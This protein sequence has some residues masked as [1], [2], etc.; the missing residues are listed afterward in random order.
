[1]ITKVA[2]LKMSLN[3]EDFVLN[4]SLLLSKKVKID[5]KHIHTNKHKIFLTCFFIRFK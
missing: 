2:F 5:N 1:M 3:F 4:N